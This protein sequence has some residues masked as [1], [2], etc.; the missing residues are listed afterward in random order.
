MFGRG[1]GVDSVRTYG[2]QSAPYKTV[3]NT[4]QFK[5]G[6]SLSDIIAVKNDTM[7]SVLVKEGRNH[8]IDVLGHFNVTYRRNQTVWEDAGMRATNPIQQFR[9]DDG[10]VWGTNG[11]RVG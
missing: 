4:L 11:Q 2:A 1:D 5:P 8:R 10:T 6:I 3:G 9:F 7:L